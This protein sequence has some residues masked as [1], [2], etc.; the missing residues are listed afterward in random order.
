MNT[1]THTQTHLRGVV[2]RQSVSSMRGGG[3]VYDEC[4]AKEVGTPHNH[5]YHNGNN[6]KDNDRQ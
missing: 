1:H 4:Q 5:N 2:T 3:A 6:E